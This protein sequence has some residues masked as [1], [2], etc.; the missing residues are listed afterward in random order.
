M[1]KDDKVYLI[2]KNELVTDMPLNSIAIVDL[3]TSSM[4]LLHWEND[5]LTKFSNN[6]VVSNSEFKRIFSKNQK[7]E[8][9]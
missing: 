6:I 2:S 9:N 4:I 1:K 5:N 3:I 8:T 7:F